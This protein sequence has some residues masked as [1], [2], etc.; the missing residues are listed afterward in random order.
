MS[1]AEHNGLRVDSGFEIRNDV[2]KLLPLETVTL[3]GWDETR[4]G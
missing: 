1:L 3:L 4:R 2:L